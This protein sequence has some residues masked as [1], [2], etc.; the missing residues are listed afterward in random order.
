MMH[1]RGCLN[2]IIIPRCRKSGAL[3]GICDVTFRA[4]ATLVIVRGSRLIT[5]PEPPGKGSMPEYQT[6]LLEK[7]EVAEGTLAFKLE[8]PAGFE[9]RAGQSADL[10]LP[11]PSESDAGG[12]IRTFSMASAPSESSLMFATRLRDTAF[13]RNLRSMPVGTL[14][15][16]EGPMGSF[17]LHRNTAKSAVFLAGGIGITPFLSMIREAVGQRTAHQ[18]HLFYSNRR[19]EDSA[20]LQELQDMSRKHASFR[21]VATMTEAEKSK[22]PW[23]GERGFID[24][25]ML[26]RHLPALQGPIYYMAGPPAMVTA[27]RQLIVNEGVDEDDIR[28]EDFA[29]Y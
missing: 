26:K 4:L 29:G 27:M 5:V 12:D 10:T 3:S 17:N 9:F 1:S 22:Q 6:R 23:E 13:K 15:R 18:I 14:I 24:A 20:F 8:K 11:S 28:A 2:F 16:I 19:P 7:I 21:L 25:A